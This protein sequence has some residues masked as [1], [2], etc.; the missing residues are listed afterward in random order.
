MN[1]IRAMLVGVAALAL[2][3]AAWLWVTA[4]SQTPKVIGMEASRLARNRIANTETPRS[5]TAHPTPSTLPSADISAAGERS[6]ADVLALPGG[7]LRTHSLERFAFESAERGV[8]AAV[9]ILGEITDVTDRAA[10][11]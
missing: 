1:S 4:F 6:L 3:V 7:F 11:L 8:D 9:R 5:A 10:F 2:A